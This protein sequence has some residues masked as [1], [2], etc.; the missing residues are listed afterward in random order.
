M[1]ALQLTVIILIALSFVPSGAHLIELPNK[2]TL[3]RE[4]YFT[5]QQIYRGWALF[6]IPLFAAL[7]TS[8]ILAVL[9]RSEGLP[10]LYASASFILVL[11]SLITFFTWIFPANQATEN[12][13]TIPENWEALRRQWEYTHAV[14]AVMMLAA[15]VSAIMSALTW[16]GE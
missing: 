7:S 15:L 4:A 13:T 3:D 12:W 1:K 8:L 2:I 14:N 10:F 9:S 11:V 5:V 16:T 6:G